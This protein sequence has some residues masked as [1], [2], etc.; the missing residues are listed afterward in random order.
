MKIGNSHG[1]NS[2][3]ING[4]SVEKVFLTSKKI[5]KKI[6]KDSKPYLIE[7]ET[8]RNLEHC[9]PNNDDNLNYRNVKYLSTWKKKCPLLVY[10]KQLKMGEDQTIIS[11][12]Q[13]RLWLLKK[14]H[15]LL[16]SL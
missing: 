14:K 15:I 12:Q 7:L 11:S 8:F 6:R 1:I 5:I 4:N 9:G 16:I 3:R 13:C 2:I 10:K